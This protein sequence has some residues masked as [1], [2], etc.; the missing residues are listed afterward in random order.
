MTWRGGE[1]IDTIQKRNIRKVAGGD[2]HMSLSRKVNTRV[3]L[4]LFL[5]YIEINEQKF[6]ASHNINLCKTT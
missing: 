6:K 2:V 5:H 4:A 3:G 1:L